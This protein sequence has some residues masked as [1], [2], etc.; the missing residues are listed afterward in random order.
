M[1]RKWKKS[2]AVMTAM[3]MA[4]VLDLAVAPIVAAVTPDDTNVDFSASPTE[5]QAPLRVQFTDETRFET[6]TVYGVSLSDVFARFANVSGPCELD[7]DRPR[8][9][10]FGDG[11]TSTAA[12]PVNTYWRPGKYTVTLTLFFK[13]LSNS[14]AQGILPFDALLPGGSA[15]YS[16]VRSW[17]SR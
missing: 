14:T 3:A 17:R 10:E 5:G 6:E 4:L 11:N 1:F 8:L 7:P 12:N 15:G 16:L 13:C 2:L 9:W